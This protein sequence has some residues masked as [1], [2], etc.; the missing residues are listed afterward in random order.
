MPNAFDFTASPFDSLNAEERQLVR[1]AVDIA[2]FRAGDVV[3][4]LGAEPSH[5]FVVIK[6]HV[7]QHDGGE[8]VAVCGPHD[9]FDGLA[10]RSEASH[11][12]LVSCRQVGLYFPAIFQ[13]Y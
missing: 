2:Y 6:G 13:S 9:C 12:P 8:I 11:C 5:L 7:A 4:E 1:D 3:L 10:G